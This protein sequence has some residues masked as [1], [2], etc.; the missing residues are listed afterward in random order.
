DR[1]GAREVRRPALR[2][3]PYPAGGRYLR[4]RCALRAEA[5]AGVPVEQAAGLGEDRR[6][7]GGQGRRESAHVDRLG[8]DGGRDTGAGRIDREVRA[9]V[10]EAEKDEL[11]APVDVGAPR[12]N[13]LPVERRRRGGARERLQVAQGQDARL[14][15][16]EQRGDP[17]AV[18]PPLA[19]PIE[20][21]AGEAVEVF[22]RRGRISRA[23]PTGPWRRTARWR[24]SACG[25]G[26]RG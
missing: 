19:D 10:A 5:M 2:A 3:A 22:H 17:V 8:V 24:R 6:L 20:R 12:R 14:W 1:V 18:V 16:A 13:G 21:V 25:A 9:S 15:V 11:G 26:P 4:R 23:A 7:A